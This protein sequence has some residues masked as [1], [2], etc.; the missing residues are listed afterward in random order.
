MGRSKQKDEFVIQTT[1]DHETFV[2]KRCSPSYS[3]KSQDSGFSDESN[4]VIVRKLKSPPKVVSKETSKRTEFFNENEED[5]DPNLTQLPDSARERVDTIYRY[6][7]NNA[8]NQVKESINNIA[9]YGIT[10]LPHESA[11]AKANYFSS[12]NEG[13]RLKRSM[14]EEDNKL[15]MNF[16]R[17]CLN[18]SNSLKNLTSFEADKAATEKVPMPRPPPLSPKIASDDDGCQCSDGAMAFSTPL[19]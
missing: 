19:R 11:I 8:A 5:S 18:V 13:L 15:K 7:V 6:S 3:T 17:Q 14:A 12:I 1:A 10:V 9:R 16:Y 2:P 4:G